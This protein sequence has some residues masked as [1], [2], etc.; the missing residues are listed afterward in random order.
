MIW[1]L[2]CTEPRGDTTVF[3]GSYAGLG[4]LGKA[5]SAGMSN[6][7]FGGGGGWFGGGGMIRGPAGLAYSVGDGISTVS[8]A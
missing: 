7:I 6:G 4:A 1:D 5:D 8:P 2:R 3:D